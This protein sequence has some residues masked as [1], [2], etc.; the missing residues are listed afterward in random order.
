MRLSSLVLTTE[1]IRTLE[2]NYIKENKGSWGQ[3]LM[4]IAGRASAQ[5][6]FEMWTET[7]G[8]VLVMC[9]RGNNGGDGLVVARYLHLWGVPV[10]VAIIP[11]NDP[12]KT[13]FEMNTPEGNINRSIVERMKIPITV[14]NSV[15]SY[16]T[17]S[18]IVDALLGTGIYRDVQ[19]DY[20]LAIDSIN[21]SATRVAAIDIPSGIN[22]D[23]GQIMGAAVR[24]DCTITFGY[25]KSGLLC[26][27][28]F[29]QA[30]DLSVI[31]IGLPEPGTLKPN[32]NLSMAA[33]IRAK[34][35]L[36]P[37][38]SH[39]G[40][41]GTTL[42]IA[43][44][45]GMLGATMFASESALRVGAGLSLLAVPSSL[46]SH[47]PAAEVIYRA[48]PETK[49][50]SIS[51][52]ALKVLEDD[53]ERASAVILGP[54]ISMEQETV[55]FVQKF[56]QEILKGSNKPCIIDADAL[57]ALAQDTSILKGKNRNIVL[58]PH[59]KELARLMNVDTKEIQA[60]RIKSGQEAATKFGCVVVLK[61]AHTI[62]A[63]PDGNVFINPTGNSGMATAGAGDVLSG[64]IGG[65]LAQGLSALDAAL[66]GV[67]IHGLAG[68]VAAEDL[69][70][71][72]IVAGDISNS[73]PL[74]LAYLNRGER[75]EFEEK[76]I[77]RG[78]DAD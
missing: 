77:Q 53:F 37:V 76:L 21:C 7:A 50:Q 22:S 38:N 72:G 34:L 32:I 2:K 63:D 6:V 12:E 74:A 41:F 11:A 10:S 75:P 48:L 57:N 46:I 29:D 1:Q 35:P 59:P 8:D 70:E 14:A 27:P 73:I 60:N 20:R 67:Y 51:L 49:S 55:K 69:G 61:G 71:V 26:E 47:L 40:T 33:L 42:T 43:G 64:T 15:P 13:D 45:L 62:V 78:R 52:E 31:D 58:T 44:S 24:A 56:I 68:D 5:A 4:E 17:Q 19:G 54:G 65:L 28:G 25:L 36:R 3:V 23:S 30:G 66:V 39:K 9:G 16:G 18:I